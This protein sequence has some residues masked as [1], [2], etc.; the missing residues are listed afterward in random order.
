MLKRHEDILMTR[1]EEISTKQV[2]Q[3][4]WNELYLWYGVQKIAVKTYRDLLDRW[5]SVWTDDEDDELGFIDVP[6]GI[7]LFRKKTVGNLA[8]RC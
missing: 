7:C 2:T 3:I 1:L 5:H 4:A 8:D 6:G